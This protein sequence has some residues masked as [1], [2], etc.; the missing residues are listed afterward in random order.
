MGYYSYDPVFSDTLRA[1]LNQGKDYSFG[2][3][4]KDPIDR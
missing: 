4:P 2:Q 1:R 3:N